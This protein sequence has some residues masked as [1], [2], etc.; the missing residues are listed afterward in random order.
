[1][2]LY[3]TETWPMTKAEIQRLEAAH[4]KWLRRIINISWK[5]IVHNDSV[6]EQTCHELLVRADSSGLERRLRWLGHVRRMSDDKI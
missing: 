1:M 2:L 6:R 5:D 3:S 4:H